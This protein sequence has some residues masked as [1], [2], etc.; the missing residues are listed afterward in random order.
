M[1]KKIISIMIL[2]SMLYSLCACGKTES[3]ESY[4]TETELVQ[5]ESSENETIQNK[6]ITEEN[7]FGMPDWLTAYVDYMEEMENYD[8]YDR[9]GFLYVDEDDIPEFVINTGTYETACIVLTFHDGE[10]DVLQTGGL[11]FR[12]IEKKNLLCDTS[13]QA[14]EYANQV[15]SIEN[16]KWVYMTGGKYISEVKD[17]LHIDK[18]SFEWEGEKVEEELYWERL[19][20]VFDEKLAIVPKDYFR[21]DDMLSHMK[22]GDFVWETASEQDTE[23]DRG[24]VLVDFEYSDEYIPIS[25]VDFASYKDELSA[26]DWQAL[27]SFFPVLL[28]GKTFMAAHCTYSDE[29]TDDLEEYSINGLYAGW[30]SEY[31]AEFV[32]DRFALCDLTGDGQKELAVYSNLYIG[33]YCV[34][35]KEGD[36]FYAVYMPVRWFEDLQKNGIFAGSGGAGTRYFHRL[37]FLRDVFWVEEVAMYD[38][39]RCY[40]INSEEVSEAEIAAWEDEML[41][42][43]AVWYDARAIKP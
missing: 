28:E 40:K 18:Y 33:L 7:T 31:P 34:F 27:S 23:K 3:A 8:P 37:H 41:V 29:Y 36:H 43:E 14:G 16:G 15:Y 12:Y 21:C 1:K 30:F 17:G 39:D 2:G 24:E 13:G 6:E 32:L 35:H 20:L 38:W 9:C 42:G 5:E 11:R 4:H 26:E 22:A 25:K 19:H 10:V